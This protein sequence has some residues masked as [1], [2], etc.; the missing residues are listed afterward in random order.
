M[1]KLLYP[2]QPVRRIITEPGECG[3]PCFLTNL[4]LNNINDWEINVFSPSLHQDLYENLEKC[5]VN[6]IPINIIQDILSEEDLDLLVEES[7]YHKNFENCK[8]ELETYESL[9]EVK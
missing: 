8:T 3:K 9:Q 6:F 7:V 1:D 2:I 4:A 5:V